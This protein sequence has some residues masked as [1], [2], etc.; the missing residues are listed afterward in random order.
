MSHAGLY[1]CISK[2]L[3]K[4]RQDPFYII[5]E[6]MY[7]RWQMQLIKKI[8]ASLWTS[9]TPA[10]LFNS[11]VCGSGKEKGRCKLSIGNSG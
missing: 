6:D 5:D 8:V 3:S 7:E 1:L 10:Y 2:G 4:L 9:L 11:T